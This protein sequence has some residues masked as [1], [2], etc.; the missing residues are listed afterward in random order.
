MIEKCFHYRSV[1]TN[2]LWYIMILSVKWSLY[3]P[4]SDWF[5]FFVQFALIYKNTVA[6][7]AVTVHSRFCIPSFLHLPWP[8]SV[9]PKILRRVPCEIVRETRV[10]FDEF[11]LC[12][13]AIP[14]IVRHSVHT[15]C[16]LSLSSLSTTYFVRGEI[17]NIRVE[18]PAPTSV[19]NQF[20]LLWLW[21]Y[22]LLSRCMSPIAISRT[23]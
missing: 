7:V 6:D 10:Q 14:S 20:F 4:I 5:F 11:H 17:Y 15:H 8:I 16:E 23:V 12:A 19:S 2:I 9:S 18:Q 21:S 1:N 13:T 22:I 3:Q